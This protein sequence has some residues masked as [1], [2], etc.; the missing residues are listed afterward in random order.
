M[1]LG[2]LLPELVLGL[3]LLQI[4]AAPVMVTT[5]CIQLLG[6]LTI[7]LDQFNRLAPGIHAMDVEDLAWPSMSR[8][9]K[10]V[11]VRACVCACTTQSHPNR[12]SNTR[13]S[14]YQQ[15]R[16]GEPQQGGRS[17]AGHK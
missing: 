10:G 14:G 9:G 17:M 7:L 5:K 12:C 8:S 11:W 4:K 1:L 16:H 15:G 3:M 6:K 2:L 13:A